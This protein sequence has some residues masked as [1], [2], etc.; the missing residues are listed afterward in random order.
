MKDPKRRRDREGGRDERAIQ[1]V[2]G[3][4]CVSWGGKCSS[5]RGPGT[6]GP[7]EQAGHLMFTQKHL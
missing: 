4:S 7:F 1:I 3:C 6:Q 5:S 2:G